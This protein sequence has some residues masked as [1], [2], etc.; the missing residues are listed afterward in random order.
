MDVSQKLDS[1]GLPDA[2]QC[3]CIPISFTDEYTA[4]RHDRA[5]YSLWAHL[6]ET[7]LRENLPHLLPPSG[8][9]PEDPYGRYRNHHVRGCWR[10]P[11]FVLL[12]EK[13]EIDKRNGVNR[14][15]PFPSQVPSALVLHS[16]KPSSQRSTETSAIAAMLPT[17]APTTPPFQSLA[18][19]PIAWT[20]EVAK[21]RGD[22]S[23]SI[24]GEIDSFLTAETTNENQQVTRSHGSIHVI[25]A[26][27]LKY[28]KLIV[29]VFM[30]I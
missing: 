3:Y 7:C 6:I 18:F 21:C 24:L 20:P 27:A 4:S 2:N 29:P 22:G 28:L 11:I 25:N 9:H 26:V 16:K 5:I 15:P 13:D 17:C 30:S 23:S 10:L 12:S 8:L 1:R 14:T 19:N